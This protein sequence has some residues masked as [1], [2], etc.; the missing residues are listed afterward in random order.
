MELTIAELLELLK[1]GGN[2]A[3]IFG[4]YFGSRVLGAVTKAIT[5]FEQIAEDVAHVR[6]RVDAR[7]PE[8]YDDGRQ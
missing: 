8:D 2:V 6:K 1:G 3:M 5:T 7:F 4:I